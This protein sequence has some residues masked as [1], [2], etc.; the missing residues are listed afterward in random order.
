MVKVQSFEEVYD[1][2]IVGGGTAGLV[3]A[4]RL[5][6]NPNITVLVLE[7]G[8]DHND[9]QRVKTPALYISLMDDPEF[10]WTFITEPQVNNSSLCYRSDSKQM[11]ILIVLIPLLL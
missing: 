9:D 8:N 5:S 11:F 7:A 2:I 10:D 3:V 6:E 1:F 4:R